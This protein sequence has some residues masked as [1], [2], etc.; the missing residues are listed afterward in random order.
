MNNKEKLNM[1]YKEHLSIN[2]RFIQCLV[3]R[4]GSKL[5]AQTVQY[6]TLTHQATFA[7]DFFFK[8]D[9]LKCW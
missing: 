1:P 2:K 8:P 5:S 3:M 9:E 4:S 6:D 7:S